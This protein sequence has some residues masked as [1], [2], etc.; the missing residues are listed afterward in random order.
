MRKSSL[1]GSRRCRDDSVNFHSQILPV[2]CGK[3]KG[4][5][6]KKRLKQGRFHGL[7]DLQYGITHVD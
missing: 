3:V 5:L 1:S 4:M 2:A 7:L 6:Y